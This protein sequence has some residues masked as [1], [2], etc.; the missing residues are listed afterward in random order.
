MIST[1]ELRHIIEA[2]FAPLSCSCTDNADGSLMVKVFD[3]AT[4][5]VDLLV[6][7]IAVKKLTNSRAIS[8]LIAELRAEITEQKALR[9]SKSN[10]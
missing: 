2:G 9:Q 3:A 10:A 4:G 5:R 6:T 1:L 7:G 8:N